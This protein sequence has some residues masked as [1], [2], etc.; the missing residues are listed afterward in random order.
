MDIILSGPGNKNISER[1]RGAPLL[2]SPCKGHIELFSNRR[3]FFFG[4]RIDPGNIC[5]QDPALPVIPDG[6][7]TEGHHIVHCK[8]ASDQLPGVILSPSAARGP[9][10][11]M[12]RRG[13]CFSGHQS[14]ISMF[15][16]VSLRPGFRL[17]EH[18]QHPAA[19]VCHRDIVQNIDRSDQGDQK[20]RD[21]CHGGD[22]KFFLECFDHILKGFYKKCRRAGSAGGISN[23]S[24]T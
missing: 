1:S 22:N 21:G 19:A 7:I 10:F 17:A 18:I 8:S 2:L 12:V 20:D 4:D 3:S 24:D 15:K 5:L 23:N 9:V 6:K 14:F 13:E 11:F 16:A